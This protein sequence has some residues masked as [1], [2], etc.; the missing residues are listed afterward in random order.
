MPRHCSITFAQARALAFWIFRS[1]TIRRTEYL[2][3]DTTWHGKP[4]VA[5]EAVAEYKDAL[6][7]SITLESAWNEWA[8]HVEPPK[9]TFLNRLAILHA[10]IAP[11]DKTLAA[12][13]LFEELRS[14]LTTWNLPTPQIDPSQAASDQLGFIAVAETFN[15]EKAARADLVG[16]I[17]CAKAVCDQALGHSLAASLVAAVE[18]GQ[19]SNY[20]AL[21]QELQQESERRDRAVRCG[22]LALLLRQSAPRFLAFLH[23]E[24]FRNRV[25]DNLGEWENA[26][27]W[28][29]AQLWVDA[30]VAAHSPV[31]LEAE[32]QKK[33][34]A[35]RNLT[36]K[37]AASKAW[38]S[39]LLALQHDQYRQGSLVA[40]KQTIAR[41][42]KG[43]GTHAETHRRTAR[44]YLQESRTAIPAW[45]M[46]FYRV[47]EQVE[48]EP[49]AFDVAII[50]E[51]SQ[52]GPEGLLVFFL[53]K[54]V[55]VVGDDKQISP[56][57]GFVDQNEVQALIRQHLREVAFGDTM[58]PTSSLF[59][60]T[61]IRFGNRL[62]LREHFR[63]MPEIIR[64]SNDLCYRDTPLIPL[65]QYPPDRLE[66]L[67][68]RF[69]RDG[70]REG[71]GQNVINRQEAAAIVLEI[72]KCLADPGYVGKSFGVVSLLGEGQARLIERWLLE[73]VGPDPFSD[74]KRRLRCGDAY[75]FQG[76]ERDVMF[77]S[78]VASL[79]GVRLTPLASEQFRQ[80]FNVA[81]SRARDQMWLFHSIGESDLHP[82][83]MRRRLLQ[84]MYAEVP[85]IP[86]GDL[87][88]CES[89][90]ERDVG[91]ML[92]QRG[93]AV[94]PQFPV[95]EYRIDFVAQG[96]IAIE[97]D[98]DAFHGPEQYEADMA[99]QRML[100]RCGW[101]FIRIGGTQFYSN[102]E[103]TID[104]VMKELRRF[105]G[106]CQS[107]PTTRSSARHAIEISG[108][109]CLA[110]LGIITRGSQ[111]DAKAS[112]VVPETLDDDAE[113]PAAPA[114]DET[115]ESAQRTFWLAV[116]EAIKNVN[117]EFAHFD[118]LD[119][120]S[121]LIYVQLQSSERPLSR[122]ELADATG[123]SMQRVARST[124]SLI[125][126]RLVAEVWE[127]SLLK[128]KYISTSQ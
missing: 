45:I 73:M 105:G 38:L 61:A 43:T 111:P 66:P 102:R 14:L 121:K 117:G 8:G 95:A 49:G 86:V 77:L 116:P 85:P 75:S 126:S 59:H 67:Q 97:C 55:I 39:C 20:R 35:L 125:Q 17:G 24:A 123:I 13:A 26:W 72:S 113:S 27:C 54:K 46:P 16:L 30:F 89:Q 28:W 96:R 60:Q 56:N 12:G 63:C 118:G 122:I 110:T 98:G 19:V 94:Q 76:D 4:L 18:R 11:L 128:Y 58:L 23:D 36:S 90:F 107:E 109:D 104:Y 50:D 79:G 82:E 80:R 34:S 32:V 92:V 1:P 65:R 51:A 9:G 62:T 108:N 41:L 120:D 68:T 10:Y 112:D 57:P 101:K 44:K 7:A 37:L 52:T 114:E 33:E 22:S 25:L 15:D 40:W 100:E 31:E 106:I 71:R 5:A 78:M 53:A 88:R 48:I 47:A 2:W 91:E 81:A 127:D 64:F 84:F 70:F 83:C 69:V 21:L 103:R 42:G 115:A 74:S 99:R 3:K 87:D 119:D 29:S 6:L 124:T 93:V